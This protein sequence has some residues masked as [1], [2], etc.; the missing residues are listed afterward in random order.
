MSP[1]NTPLDHASQ[2]INHPPDYSP[3][4]S[5]IQDEVHDFISGFS[6]EQPRNSLATLVVEVRKGLADIARGE[7]GCAVHRFS[8][9]GFELRMRFDDRPEL[10]PLVQLAY[11]AADRLERRQRGGVAAAKKLVRD[12]SA[13]ATLG[14]SLVSS[15]ADPYLA[16]DRR[17]NDVST[18]AKTRQR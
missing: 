11:R 17:L 10:A 6:D 9:V 2:G 4:E 15:G 3:S 18:N 1:N 7:R 12:L 5:Q 14:A 16:P 13:L 8:F